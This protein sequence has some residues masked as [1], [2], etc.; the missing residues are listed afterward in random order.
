LSDFT[1]L[2]LQVNTGT[3]PAGEGSGSATWT[4]VLFGTA[5]Y[6]LRAALSSGSQSTSTPSASWPSMLKPSSGTT[7]IDRMYAF[8]ADTTGYQITTYDGTSAHYLQFR[9]NWDNTGTFNSAPIISAWKDNTLPAASPGTQNSATTGGD[10]TSIIN[11]TSTESNSYSLLKCNAYG[12]GLTSGGAQQTPSANAAGTL[13]VN[14]HSASGAATPSSAAWLS[15]WQDLQAAT[16]WI[17]NGGIPQATTAGLW[18]FVLSLSIA[19]SM[20][21]GTLLP[22]IGMQYTWI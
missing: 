10:G 12:Q 2:N 7:L 19:A 5:G 21:G 18:Y 13:A 4:S 15:T 8:T 9:I 17:A 3:T 11:G 16:N 6:E 20:T 14:S 22:V 1:T